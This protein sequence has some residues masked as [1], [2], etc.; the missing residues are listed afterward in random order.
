[1]FKFIDSLSIKFKITN[2]VF[3]N[4]LFLITI[5]VISLIAFNSTKNIFDGIRNKQIRLISLSSLISNDISKLQN[6][7]LTASASSLKINPNYKERNSNIQKDIELNIAKLRLLSKDKNFISLKGMIKNISL[8][9][10]S[11]GSIGMGMVEDFNDEDSDP[12]DKIDAI[13]GYDSVAKKTREELKKLVDF[14]NKTLAEKVKYFLEF[15]VKTTLSIFLIAVIAFVNT[16]IFSTLFGISIQKSLNIFQ[17]DLEE[18]DENSDLSFKKENVAKNEVGDI[19]HKLNNLLANM[20]D[21]ILEI[22]ESSENNKATSGN[23]QENFKKITDILAKNSVVIE[24][25]VLFGE[26]TISIIQETVDDSSNVKEKINLIE[27]LFR[28]TNDNLELLSNETEIAS[29][30]ELKLVADLTELNQEA[31]DVSNIVNTINDIADQ[32]N[33]LALNAAIEAARAGEHGRGFAVVADE[34]RKLAES[35]QRSIVEIN[36]TITTITQTITDV[37]EKID[38]SSKETQKVTNMTNSL[39]VKLKNNFSLI[40][41]TSQHMDK[42]FNALVNASNSTIKIVSDINNIDKESKNSILIVESVSIDMEKL[43][44][45]ANS[46]EDDLSRFKV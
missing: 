26:E 9:S 11:L 33:L 5:T 6:I 15:L 38:E 30:N 46:L 17:K 43:N 18:I 7:F 3:W 41:E 22:K 36:A 8:R 14:S 35:I 1:M 16:L 19:Y 20:R 44:S 45:A 25:T 32:T 23:A 12:I 39:R 31:R 13:E 34:V 29:Q 10:K 37:S 40:G 42:S 4:L 21:A 2:I 27:D 24:D 28:T